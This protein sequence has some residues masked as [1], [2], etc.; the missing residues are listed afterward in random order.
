MKYKINKTKIHRNSEQ[1]DVVRWNGSWGA[2]WKKVKGL[3]SANGHGGGERIW[4]TVTACLQGLILPC[5]SM[6]DGETE[7]EREKGQGGGW[8]WGLVQGGRVGFLGMS[9]KAS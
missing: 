7:N 4:N 5:V 9:I 8:G 3:K 1:T 6:E 2:G